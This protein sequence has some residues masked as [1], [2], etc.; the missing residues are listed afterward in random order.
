MVS[1][2]DFETCF[3]YPVCFL[4]QILSEIYCYRKSIPQH[5]APFLIHLK[6]ECVQ[7]RKNIFFAEKVPLVDHGGLGVS[8]CV[9]A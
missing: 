1:A 8:I 2:L 9:Y 3:L 5:R 7:A 6:K 4:N